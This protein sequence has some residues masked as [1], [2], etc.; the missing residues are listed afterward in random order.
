MWGVREKLESKMAPSLG[1][2]HQK[3]EMTLEM[4][5]PLEEQIILGWELRVWSWP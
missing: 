2:E 1:P 5:K 4:A 3:A